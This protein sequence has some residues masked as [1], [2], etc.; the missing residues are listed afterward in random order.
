M[1]CCQTVCSVINAQ[2]IP[3]DERVDTAK[4][5]KADPI[6][7]RKPIKFDNAF[8]GS[9][10]NF[11]F[12]GGLYFHCAPYTGY[13]FKDMLAL[14]AGFSYTFSQT[15]QS[16]GV[17]EDHRYG[18][19]AFARFRPFGK[20]PNA[21]Y[22]SNMYGHLEMESMNQQILNPN[23]NQQNP[24]PGVPQ[25]QRGFIQTAYVGIGYTSNFGKGFGVTMDFLYPIWTSVPF[26]NV[27]NWTV[28]LSY[29]IGVYA[30]F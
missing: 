14:A 6:K 23:Y 11:A 27:R 18:V 9:D 10:F 4:S 16:R 7:V 5:R 21:T 24:T 25:F 22:I 28:L 13:R 8:V 17:Y 15:P 3:N 20:L 12:L 19:R 30:G 26:S 1:L 2:E 29:R